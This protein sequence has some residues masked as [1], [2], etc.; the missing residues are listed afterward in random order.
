MTGKQ[1]FQRI[2]EIKELKW[3]I[4]D[5]STN[6]ALPSKLFETTQNIEEKGFEF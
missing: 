2:L 1:L 5:L 4:S 6:I 3:I